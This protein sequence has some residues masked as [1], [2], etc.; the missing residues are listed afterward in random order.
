MAPSPDN[1]QPFRP[2]YVSVTLRLFENLL[3]ALFKLI[4][5]IIPWHKLPRYMGMA[6]LLAFRIVLRR[7]NLHD[8]DAPAAPGSSGCPFHGKRSS[9]SLYTRILS[10]ENNDLSYPHMGCAGA[11]FGRNVPR[12]FTEKPDWERMM[13]PHPREISNRLL[14]RPND[15]ELKATSINLLAAAWIQFQVHDWFNHEREEAD[16]YEIDM[17]DPAWGNRKMKL[18]RTKPDM[19]RPGENT[20]IPAYRNEES[21][22]WDASQV[23]GTTEEH[24]KQLRGEE[25]DG[26]LSLEAKANGE[27]FLPL[28]PSG[29]ADTGFNNNWWVGLE[30][31]H[32]LFA[33]EHNAICERLRMESPHCSHD[34]IFETAHLIN[35]ALMAKIHTVEWT[36]AILAHP[37]IDLALNA[38][39]W[40][41]LGEKIYKAFGRVSTTDIFSGIPGS[42]TDHHA[43]PYALTEEFV[44][45]Y[46]LHPLIPERVDF[47]SIQ[48]GEL[49][50]SLHMKDV[51]FTNARTPFEKGLSF[52]D[53]F[54]SF[55][56]NYPGAITLRNYPSF[57]R[58]IDLPDGLRLDVGA[59]DILRDRERGV[60]R[61]NQFRELLHRG[62]VSS[63]E[64]LTGAD[65]DSSRQE[66]ADEIRKVYDGKIDDVDLMVGMFA[67]PLP[68]GFAFS[69]TAFRVFIL[70]A[71]R[72]LKSDRFF[73]TDWRPE[74]YTRF[75]IEWVQKNTM[76]DILIRH[77]PELRA[78][79]RDVKNAFAPW[80]DVASLAV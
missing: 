2:K 8:T 32:T 72:R 43:A 15:K 30:L 42:E 66:L 47:Y 55:G 77:H 54:Y 63:F 78:A 50:E 27:L 64:E 33:K 37:V 73:T 26:K 22:W 11:R 38:N 41:V 79:L 31:L 4:N 74:V 57:L 19:V 36:P 17:N 53:I 44:A 56:R 61:Y 70:M 71:S 35:S 46:R 9:V 45:V 25:K 5:L 29:L 1:T 18:P 13:T 20:R 24:I 58:N 60:P 10:G 7:Q 23:Y 3:I 6:N 16:P 28:G 62:R 14:A 39:W 21:H 68:K 69:D 67:E 40:G 80:N 52:S 51:A 65:H 34:Q 49:V 12:N 75:G 59:V 48:N 76:R